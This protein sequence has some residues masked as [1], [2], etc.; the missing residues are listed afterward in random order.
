MTWRSSDTVDG[1][2]F[3]NCFLTSLRR[4]ADLLLPSREAIPYEEFL[5][6]VSSVIGTGSTAFYLFE[7]DENQQLCGVGVVARR[8][9]EA[10]DTDS[11][12]VLPARLPLEAA[13]VLYRQMSAHESRVM[14]EQQLPAI[15][16]PVLLDAPNQHVLLL[17]LKPG[18]HLEATLVCR[19]CGEHTKW[20]DGEQQ[21]LVEA[22]SYLE[23]FIMRF[24]VEKELAQSRRMVSTLMS[25]LPGMA[26]H[27]SA[28]FP[29]IMKYISEGCRNLLGAPYKALKDNTEMVFDELICPEDL[30]AVKWGLLDA[31]E[32]ETDY[33]L[34]YRIH[35]QPDTIRWVWDRGCVVRDADRL[36]CEGFM[37]DITQRKEAEEKIIRSK[38]EWE[39]TFDTVY[40][41][42]VIL[43]SH[44]RVLRINQAAADHMGLPL[45]ACIGQSF[46]TFEENAED[47]KQI[48]N[49]VM[50][51]RLG[52]QRKHIHLPS[53]QKDFRVTS[54]PFY[55]E[56]GDIKG[57][58]YVA[59][60]IT[61]LKQS[62][63]KRLRLEAR[64]QQAQ[65]VESLGG[66]A[67]GIAHDFNNILQVIRGNADLIQAE[68]DDAG[69]AVSQMLT[70]IQDASDRAAGLC[71]QML[72]YSGKSPT[73]M[74]QLDVHTV[75]EDVKGMLQTTISHRAELVY[76]L[77][78]E[79]HV[80]YADRVLIQQA[81]INLVSN[82]SDAL[83]GEKGT[84]T[85]QTANCVP[86]SGDALIGSFNGDRCIQLQIKDSG[87]GIEEQNLLAIFDPFYSTKFLGRGLGLAAVQGIVRSHNGALQIEQPKGGGSS[88][89]LYFPVQAPVATT[90]QPVEVP[91]GR[92]VLLVD[93]ERSVLNITEKNLRQVGLQVATA[94]N[95]RQALEVLAASG[96]AISV[97]LLDLIMPVMD[98]TETLR[99][100]RKKSC[101]IPVVMMSGYNREMS[102]A[103]LHGLKIDGFIQKPFTLESL[104]SEL[105]SAMKSKEKT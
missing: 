99:E 6:A 24:K 56:H 65:K 64:I 61:D 57:R 12:S 36:V 31:A 39:R 88:F 54:A 52:Y 28:T 19:Q 105:I 74:D 27:S 9:S 92:T 55:G 17:P 11:C 35:I 95:G 53:L 72:T 93:D 13:E 104:L 86:E 63:E 5:D 29:R 82:A 97:I 102:T 70:D 43:D 91:P 85:V 76:D 67:A 48:E 40:D 75:L 1:E 26:Y 84:I 83:K 22:L 66:M 41:P 42:I 2:Q 89:Q 79:E 51:E 59:H 50:E 90:A 4:V 49:P 103:G 20:S 10:C 3:N 15:L 30:P 78:A 44:Y 47:L 34:I 58:T 68:L 33:Q 98:G 7:R 81:F 69:T 94:A 71:K 16:K 25:N 14:R 62:E 101:D 96:D 21:F 87:S 37:A 45:Q 80:I 60:D 18:H 8:I 23:Q 32:K 38:Q 77:G 46:F 73:T 100:I